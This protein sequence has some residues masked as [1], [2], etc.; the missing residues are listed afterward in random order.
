MACVVISDWARIAKTTNKSTVMGQPR[1]KVVV[2]GGGTAG[3]MTAAAITTAIPSTLASVTLIESEAIGIIGVGEATLPHLKRFNDNL[4]ID[5]ASFMKATSATFKLGI[6]F[7]NW[8]QRGDAYFHPFGDYGVENQSIGFHHFWRRL[9]HDSEVGDFSRY[10]VPVM[11]AAASKFRHPDE[12]GDRLANSYGYAYQL[13]ATRYA[14]FLRSVAEARGATRVEGFVA[15]TH[16]NGETGD[17]ESVALDDGRVIDGTLFVDCS[18]F[19][20]LLIEQALQAGYTNWQN[21]LPCDRAVAMPSESRGATLPYTQAIAE[22]SGWRWRIPLQ[23]RMGNGLVYCSQFMDADD[24]TSCLLGAVPE[25]ELSAPRQLRFTTGKRNR[26][27]HHNCVAIGLSGGFLEPLE[28]TSIY[29]IQAAVEQLIAHFPL[30]ADYAVE[31][32][33]F[34]RLLDLEF[35]RVRDFLVLHYVATERNDSEFWRYMRHL[36]L[37]DSLRERIELFSHSGHFN[38][39]QQGLFLRPSWLAVMLGQGIVPDHYDVR[40]DTIDPGQLKQR[41][42]ELRSK[43]E[44]AVDGMPDHDAYLRAYCRERAA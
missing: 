22:A 34:N 40:V 38:E 26:M 41:L 15:Q 37:P 12:T 7:R 9:A 20:G 21:W 6:E 17:I 8:G 19:N 11:A 28:S 30:D 42:C 23:H 29:L 33:A 10:S 35:V 36:Q 18:G 5:E 1:H 27:W 3:W 39:Y 32:E 14:P 44:T 13:D 31:R 43:I 25:P 24:A 4:G 2:V 16:R